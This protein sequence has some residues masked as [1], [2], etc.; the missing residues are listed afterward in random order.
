[1]RGGEGNGLVVVGQQ[2]PPIGSIDHIRAADDAGA[3]VGDPLHPGGMKQLIHQVGESA[4][5]VRGEVGQDRGVEDDDGAVRRGGVD[6]GGEPVDGIGGIDA[7]RV[8][9]DDVQRRRQSVEAVAM[10]WPDQRA[11]PIAVDVGIGAKRVEIQ[12][13]APPDVGQL[14]R[15]RYRAVHIA[16]QLDG[17]G[18]K[19]VVLARY[20]PVAVAV[21]IGE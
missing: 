18:S 5:V 16:R 4:A 2:E 6:Q 9:G 15:R 17:T 10:F 11:E 12:A 20:G 7:W 3:F 21:A 1:M 13:G 14:I 8:G 19:A